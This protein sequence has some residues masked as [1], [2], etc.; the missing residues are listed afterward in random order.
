[1]Q[2]D[3]PSQSLF[4]GRRP[5]P[6]SLLVGAA[7]GTGLAAKAAVRG[8]CDMLLALNAG[9]FRSMGAPSHASLLPL[10][11]SNALVME[12]G[13]VE[14]LPARGDVPAFFGACCFDPRQSLEELVDRIAE[15]GFQGITN[16]PTSIFLEGDFRQRVEAAG[17]GFDREVEMLRL[18]RGRGLL[19]LGYAATKAQANKMA[20]AQVDIVNLNLG[21][22][23]GG[24][25]GSSTSLDLAEAGDFAR[26]VFR[27][28]RRIRPATLCMVEGGPIVSALDMHAVSEAARADGYIGGST[29][30]RVPLEAAIEDA[31]SAFKMIGSLQERMLEL[32][33]QTL[34]RKRDYGLVGWSDAMVR[35]RR[36]IARLAK[37]RQTILLVGAPGTG[38]EMV[39]R[40]LASEA[41]C[42]EF[43]TVASDEWAEESL[44]GAA[45][46]NSRRHAAGRLGLLEG[47][48]ETAIFIENAATLTRSLQAPLLAAVESGRFL[49]LG[50]GRTQPVTARIILAANDVASM[51]PRL[52]DLLSTARIDLPPLVQR[53]EDLPLLIAH[54]LK[55][56]GHAPGK[57]DPSIYRLLM[58]HHWP[59]NVGELR[60]VI[61]RAVVTAA[62]AMIS[63]DHLPPFDAPTG[64]PPGGSERDWILD[65]LRRHRFRRTET[66]AFLGISRK[67]LYNK[68]QAFEIGDGPGYP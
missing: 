4:N 44:F 23:K 40:S 20:E 16:F 8:G 29:I 47:G 5:R 56:A 18:A 66:A 50:D 67:T 24:H 1:M 36:E 38:K 12:F 45:A 35:V 28:V 39:A 61:E 7:I 34:R 43:I 68:M 15:A 62:G 41:R 48:P 22:N 59:R 53:L 60:S 63:A 58:A 55:M 42:R 37:T 25:Q 14:I 9:K 30:D 64:V 17:V 46:G 13:P 31:A 57:V 65:A 19:T 6:G 52:L 2:K 51:E 10:R 54:F 32:E 11:D 27:S 21:W 49:R 33:R 3:C 26:S